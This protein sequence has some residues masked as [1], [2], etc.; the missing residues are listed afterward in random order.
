MMTHTKEHPEHAKKTHAHKK[1]TH[2]TVTH[3]HKTVT[4]HTKHH[5]AHHKVS[6]KKKHKKSSAKSTL[7]TIVL[8]VALAVVAWLLFKTPGSVINLWGGVMEGDDV[9]IM[10]TASFENGRVF[11]SNVWAEPLLFTVGDGQVVNGLDEGVHG[12]TINEKKTIVI[13]PDKWYG[14]SYNKRNGEQ[15]IPILMF[16]NLQITPEE[17]VYYDLWKFKWEIKEI[18]LDAGQ[19]IVVMD[20]NPIHTW[21]DLTY[22]IEVVNIDRNIK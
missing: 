6:H 8:V 2:K 13:S 16:K 4:H 20:T 10:Y 19:K 12:M 17:G 14:K 1:T 22:E 5:T 11:E 7:W 3:P 18:V 9:S 15:R 21:K